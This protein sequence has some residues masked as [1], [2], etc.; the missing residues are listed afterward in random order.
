M[1]KN[2]IEA[3]F[4]VFPLW[5]VT[6]EKQC[7]C[8]TIDCDATGK[9]PRNSRWQHTPE[10]SDEQI[11]N[12]EELGWFDT[13][14]GVLCD[15]YLIIDIDER[16]DGWNSYQRLC[17]KIPEIQACEFIVQTG[18]GGNN[19]HMYFKMSKKMPLV[20]NLKE[21]RGIDFKSKGYVVGA[22]S[23]HRTGGYYRPVVGSPNDV[24]NAPEALISLLERKQVNSAVV[25]GVSV[26][27]L[28][29]RLQKCWRI[30]TLI[31]AM[32]SGIG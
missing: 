25:D 26:E 24:D 7:E 8:G 4:R 12:M 6:P 1:H 31:V 14:F 2:Y 23:R 13:G 22:G 28:T 17:E 3:G 32:R 5:R 18:S 10:W 27:C 30:L 29:M 19:K 15:G 9:H 21:Y 11:E 16:N 20:Q